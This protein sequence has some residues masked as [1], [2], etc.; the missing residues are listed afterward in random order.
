[1]KSNLQYLGETSN[2]ESLNKQYDILVVKIAIGCSF[3]F[4]LIIVYF[5]LQTIIVPILFFLCALNIRHMDKRLD[6]ID[7]E[8][9]ELF[10][11]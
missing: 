7:K 4:A 6:I 3:M 8:L 11:K 1:M 5:F 10:L 9:D 2:W